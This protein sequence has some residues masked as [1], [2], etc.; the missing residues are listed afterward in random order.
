MKQIQ[1]VEPDRCHYQATIKIRNAYL[2]PD[3]PDGLLVGDLIG[4]SLLGDIGSSALLAFLSMESFRL[5][6][7]TLALK[8]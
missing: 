2:F 5:L 1:S 6:D 3:R 4:S 8:Y 7:P